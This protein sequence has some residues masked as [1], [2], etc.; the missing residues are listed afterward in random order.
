MKGVRVAEA[1][2]NMFSS[3]IAAY[4][5]MVGIPF[6]GPVL[7]PIAAASAIAVGTANI[8]KIQSASTGADFITSG[9]QMLLVG[10][11]P[12]QREKVE[13]T[14]LSSPNVSGPGGSNPINISFS[15]N[16]LSEDFI[17]E[18]A[19]PLIKENLR[20]GESIG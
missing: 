9:P 15:G 20:R 17:V 8:Q 10:D 18:Q 13:V 19:I 11:N 1:T 5:S 14:P 4:Q 2:M 3:A 7:A 6:V 12:G 16:V